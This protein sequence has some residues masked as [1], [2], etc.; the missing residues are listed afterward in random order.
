VRRLRAA[1]RLPTTEDPIFSMTQGRFRAL[2]TPHV[3][4]P[5][6]DIDARL[7]AT[8]RRNLSAYGYGIKGFVL[9]LV[10]T[11]IQVTEGKHPGCGHPGRSS[12][13]LRTLRQ[14]SPI[15]LF[16]YLGK[17]PNPLLTALPKSSHPTA[18]RASIGNRP[19]LIS[20]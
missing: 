1:D 13:H 8:E 7:I 6:H 15:G 5:A 9:S 10:E 18:P 11:A 2:L 3:D 4:I 16:G 20:G 14:Q 19:K 12:A 17:A